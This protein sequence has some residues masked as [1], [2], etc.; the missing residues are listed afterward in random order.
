M[1]ALLLLASGEGGAAEGAEHAVKQY[2]LPHDINEVI[3]GTIAFCLVVGFLWW[4]AG[5]AIKKAMAGRTQR[6][7]NEL[8]A[9]SAATT[10]A[11][12][13]ADR[14]KGALVDAGG[15]QERIVSE[16]RAAAERL[17]G[18][19]IAKAEADAAAIRERAEADAA[20]IRAR[21]ATDLRAEVGTLT[22]TAAT[23]MVEASLDE[24]TQQRLIDAF[25]ADL[26]SARN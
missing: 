4:K 20:V 17:E 25:I 16:A 19:L 23:G 3:W 21:V 11:A 10:E 14:I 9:A 22:L 26:G 8:D 2:W 1:N 7:A 13:S 12:E 15:E 24:S 18:D 5:P 6:I